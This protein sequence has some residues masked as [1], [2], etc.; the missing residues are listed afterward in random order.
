MF[1]VEMAQELSS[2]RLTTVVWVRSYASP[3]EIC[4]G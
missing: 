4:G 2:R 1:V 3:C